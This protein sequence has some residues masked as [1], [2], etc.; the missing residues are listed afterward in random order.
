MGAPTLDVGVGPADGAPA[1]RTVRDWH[2][3]V[4]RRHGGG[5]LDGA[6][7]LLRRLAE[8]APDVP[9]LRRDL[10]ALLRQ[11]DRPVEADRLAVRLD[12]S[13]TRAWARLA[14][15]AHRTRDVDLF[16][17]V[18]LGREAAEPDDPVARHFA[19]VARTLRDGADHQR[20]SDGYVRHVFDPY[21]DRFD[22]HLDLLRYRGP[23]VVAGL[24]H[25]LV[26]DGDLPAEATVADLGCGTGLV[27]H[28]LRTGRPGHGSTASGPTWT[29]R[30]V[31]G[32]LAPRMLER[33]AARCAGDRPVYDDV[34]EA[35]FASFLESRPDAFDVVVAA[36]AFI[37]VG[38]LR[39]VFAAATT[40]LR[41]GGW[42][43]ATVEHAD[44]GE[45]SER[46]YV[47]DMS[48]RFR[49]DATWIETQLHEAGFDP[50]VV[51][52]LSIR[53]EAHQPVPGLVTVAHLP[54]PL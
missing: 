31:G 22:D 49:H 24:V 26:A 46:G 8:A 39:P 50:V 4:R 32:D 21:A 40:A 6:I 44:R 1:P 7:D 33:A 41:P 42:L 13:D 25:D 16:V 23:Q 48:G 11:A 34:V 5:D 45:A 54:T 37:Y 18:S 36:D 14:R 38:D 19:D 20:C 53:E 27:G 43:V 28:H 10:V 17:E 3:E 51:E 52:E 12:P 2:D 35:D 30:L 9:R 29:G 15:H 47:T